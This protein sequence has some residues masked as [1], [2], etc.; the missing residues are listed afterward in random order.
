MV[1]NVINKVATVTTV[2]YQ[3]LLVR[4]ATL[5][6]W[7]SASLTHYWLR[8]TMTHAHAPIFRSVICCLAGTRLYDEPRKR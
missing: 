7:M 4:L 3:L 6:G 1:V 8:A 5:A 2:G